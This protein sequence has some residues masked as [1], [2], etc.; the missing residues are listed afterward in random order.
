MANSQVRLAAVTVGLVAF[1]WALVAAAE[2]RQPDPD[3]QVVIVEREVVVKV[4]PE[5]VTP[6]A[7]SLVD[8]DEVARQ[9]DCLWRFMQDHNLEL[10]FDMVW[11]ANEVTDALGGA[12]FVIGEDDVQED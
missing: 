8:W 4:E 12:C 6:F 3:V 5:P 2:S 1:G 9:D 11:A 7:D 10:T